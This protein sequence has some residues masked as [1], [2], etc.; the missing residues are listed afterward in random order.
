MDIKA[1][2]ESGII[3]SYVMRLT[4][5]EETADVESMMAA[6]PEIAKAVNDFEIR[7]EEHLITNSVSPLPGLKQAIWNELNPDFLP[8][9]KE[10]A[11]LTET[12]VRR[13]ATW[14]YLAA[15]SL[16][17]LLISAVLNIYYYN[18]YADAQRE[19]NGL[20][21]ERTSLFANLD[22]AQ[23]KLNVLDSNMRMMK[24]TTMQIIAMTGKNSK[25]TIYWN[26]HTKDVY[27]L[28]NQMPKA[29]EGMQYQLWA[30]VNGKPVDAGMLGNCG[31]QL[32]KMKNI[33][34]AQ[35]FAITLEKA[36]GS[37]VPTME[38]LYVIGKI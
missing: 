26:S 28:Q 30:I 2:I 33:P 31:D 21:A 17:L 36:G 19:Y 27:V 10:E 25:A 13:P 32:C 6:Y 24:D 22:A 16:V 12:A 5:P 38:Q 9:A 20:L 11:V 4:S 14:K 29:P 23:T 35:A 18:K 3:E 15:A 7:L 37:P 1:Y 34:E 8:E